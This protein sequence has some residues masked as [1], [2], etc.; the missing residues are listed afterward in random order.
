MEVLHY[1][2]CSITYEVL[3]YEVYFSAAKSAQEV[4][5]S[6]RLFVHLSVRSSYHSNF[7]SL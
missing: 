2:Y 3:A 7:D 1:H 6:I 4:Q 5:M